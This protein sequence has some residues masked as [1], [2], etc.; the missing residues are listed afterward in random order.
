MDFLVH[1]FDT[2]HLRSMPD[3]KSLNNYS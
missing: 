2:Y 3:A 1:F